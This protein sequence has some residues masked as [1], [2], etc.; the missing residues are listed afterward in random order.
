MLRLLSTLFASPPP[1]TYLH[2]WC[3]ITSEVYKDTCR[4]EGK[5]D[6]AMRDNTVDVGPPAT[7][8]CHDEE[9]TPI[10]AIIADGFGF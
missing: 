10:N 7:E 5:V 9:R 2:R 8:R 1:H 3:V 6:A 4:W